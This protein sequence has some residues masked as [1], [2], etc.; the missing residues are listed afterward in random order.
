VNNVQ[1]CDSC[2]IKIIGELRP[3]LV[4]SK[5]NTE[6]EKKLLD[7]KRQ[8]G[9]VHNRVIPGTF[10]EITIVNIL[11]L[12]SRFSCDK[13]S[14]VPFI[15]Y[16][17]IWH[18]IHVNKSLVVIQRQVN[19]VHTSYPISLRSVSILYFHVCLNPV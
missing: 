1:N 17:F 9:P 4:T 18:C 3:N 13:L 12:R 7:V 14:S 19:L 6:C 5:S 16:N 2:S 11:K 15:R 10:R 8:N